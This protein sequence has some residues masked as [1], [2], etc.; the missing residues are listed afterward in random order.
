M[1][2]PPSQPFRERD[3][4]SS[5]AAGLRPWLPLPSAEVV[6]L[7]LFTTRGSLDLQ[8]VFLPHFPAAWWKLQYFEE[9]HTQHPQSPN[10]TPKTC[11]DWAER[12][13]SLFWWSDRRYGRSLTVRISIRESHQCK[14]SLSVPSEAPSAP[15]LHVD[16]PHLVDGQ[17]NVNRSP[18]AWL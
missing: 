9:S 18:T 8:L 2:D 7:T 16:L 3:D 6:S 15:A 1:V 17:S 11:Y 13:C 10:N 14:N 4:N 5:F 12:H